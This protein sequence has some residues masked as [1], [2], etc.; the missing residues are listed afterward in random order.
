MAIDDQVAAQST[1]NTLRE[2]TLVV[3][4][5]A[6]VQLAGPS[7]SGETTLLNL[8]AAIDRP[9]NGDVVVAGTDVSRLSVRDA[10]I[11]RTKHVGFVFQS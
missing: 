11:F 7:G 6:F 8:I 3:E 4:E 1:V 5:G 10:A 2:V 9:D